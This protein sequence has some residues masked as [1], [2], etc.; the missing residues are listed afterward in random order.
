MMT[1]SGYDGAAG[2]DVFAIGKKVGSG[3]RVD[4]SGWATAR[5]GAFMKA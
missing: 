5:F 4:L 2:H 1:A 3:G